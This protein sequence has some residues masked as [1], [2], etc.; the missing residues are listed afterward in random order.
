MERRGARVT[1][2]DLPSW[3]A[4]DFGPCYELDKSPEEGLRYLQDPLLLARRLLGSR[5]EKVEMT[6]YD[7]SPETVG[8]YDLVFCGSLLLHLT[9][10]IRALWRLQSVTNEQ[11]I[12]ATAV[13]SDSSDEP[14][15]LFVGHHRGDAWWLPNRPCLEAMVKSAGFAGWEWVSDFR[16]DYADGQPGPYHGVIRAWNTPERPSA[17]SPNRVAAFKP[18]TGDELLEM[19]QLLEAREAEIVRLRNLLEGYERGNFI[20]FMKWLHGLRER[21]GS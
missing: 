20:R 11:A 5:V 8:R 12:I 17:P 9:D 7:V 21:I 6:I 15:A 4:H 16:L 10:P 14:L 18:E 13:H 2:L 1:A 19:R 3:F